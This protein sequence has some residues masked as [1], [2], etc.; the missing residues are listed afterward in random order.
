M[1][2]IIFAQFKLWIPS[3]YLMS[4]ELQRKRSAQEEALS[5]QHLAATFLQGSAIKPI[6]LPYYLL[7]EP[8]E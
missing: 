8:L 6:S 7:P 3:V 1:V 4:H 2:F 5:S